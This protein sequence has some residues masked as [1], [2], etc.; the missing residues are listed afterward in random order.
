MSTSIVSEQGESQSKGAYAIVVLVLV[1]Y[2]AITTLYNISI[3]IGEAPD[4]AD[5]IRFVEILRRT[6]QLP[7]IPKDS[8]RYSYEAEQPPLYYLIEDAW[9]RVLWPD[10]R[11]V[12]DL[13][14]NPSFSSDENFSFDNNAV[15]SVFLHDYPFERDVPGHVMRLLSSLLGLVTLLFVWLAARVAWPES[16]GAALAAVGFVA[17]LPGFTFTSATVTN[18]A[19]ATTFGAIVV[20]GCV[21]QLKRGLTISS[22]LLLGSAVG[23]GMLSKRSL[24]VMLP[25][26]VLV[27]LLVSGETRRR[28]VAA[29]VGSTAIA[30]LIGAWPLVF[31]VFTYGDPFATAATL[32]VKAELT[33][34]LVGRP[35][36]WLSPGYHIALYN[37]LWGAF[38]IRSIDLPNLL[39][40]LYYVLLLMA[41]VG[42]ALRRKVVQFQQRRGLLVLGVIFLL[43]NAGVAYQNTQ[44]WAVQGR[45][46]LPGLAALALFI[47][48]G[49]GLVVRD[50]LK[51]TR[52]QRVSLLLLLTVLLA[53]NMYA[54][55]Q[56]ILYVYYP[57]ATG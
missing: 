21:Y 18:D 10:D 29:I 47:G 40:A 25:L 27:P 39:Y 5:H 12:P 8:P 28:R 31:N 37:S 46:L 36:Y 6:N 44:F 35:G 30:W 19:L 43:V 26:L 3:P 17:F 1:V 54:L 24:L 11:L 55:I 20:F 33:S 14:L 32:A 2:L 52:A 49:L 57:A 53:A 22:T 51:S 7:T 38:G 34:P 9:I 50:L 48:Y 42:L 23:F 16:E 13:K 41:I 15:P 56:F 4:E 45:L